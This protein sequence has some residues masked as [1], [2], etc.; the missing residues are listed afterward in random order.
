MAHLR[1][2][3]PSRE[4]DLVDL[5]ARWI[6]I[7]GD[8]AKQ[9]LFDWLQTTCTEVIDKLEAFVTARNAYSQ[10]NTTENRIVKDEAKVAAVEAMREF[11]RESIRFNK[12]VDDETRAFLGVVILDNVRS[13][14]PTPRAQCTGE[15]S[16]PGAHLLELTLTG[17]SVL[18]ADQRA[19]YGVRSVGGIIPQGEVTVEMAAGAK[20][21]LATPPENG[22]VLGNS[23]FTRKKKYV[24][25][26]AG[27]SG[28]RV[29]FCCR[30]ENGKGHS[31]PFGPIIKGIIT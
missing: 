12:K 24:F 31:G 30:F 11:A 28:N 13:T 19:N 4:Q 17:F 14:I 6:L 16:N 25:D 20:H 29:F 2:W 3:L 15:V 22:E 27:E 1:D 5:I 21:Y 7:L 18:T 23:I 8:A 9:A 10:A 26:F